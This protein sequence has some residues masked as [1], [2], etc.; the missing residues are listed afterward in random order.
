MS[1]Y[2]QALA[3]DLT[4]VF[5]C[6]GLLARF[7]NL[8]LSHPAVPYIVF[9]VHTVT[10]RL[11][12]LLNGAPTLYADTIY[13]FEP[14]LA[15]EIVRAALY[16]D[17][18]FLAVTT[19]WIV[20]KLPPGGVKPAQSSIMLEARLLR[21]VLF[22]SFCL[23][24]VGLRLVTKVPGIDYYDWDPASAWNS[25]SYILMLPSWFGLA[26]LGHIYF[27][28]FKKWTSLLLA[29]YLVLMAL[30]GGLRF[31]FIIGL[32][33]AVQI[34]V[35]H[36]H[37]RW[38]TRPMFVAL[39][40]SALLFFPM[41]DAGYL[42]LY[43]GT[44]EEVSDTVTDSVTEVAAGSAGDQM[45]LDEYASGLTL[46]DLQGK[47]YYGSIYLPLLTLPVPRYFWP[48]KP[49]LAGFVTD[50]SSR[51]RP[52]ATSGMIV[53][54]LGEAYAN[55]GLAG[56]LIVPPILALFLVIFYR[57][58]YLAPPGSVMRFS[59]IL[60]AVNLI[61]VFRDG[62]VSIV[63]FTFVNMMPLVVII[64]LHLGAAAVRKRRHL[65]LASFSQ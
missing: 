56:I 50:I 65:G 20:V 23:G 46:L 2:G 47:K 51:S 24:V 32:L 44:F 17:I 26:V 36:R 64:L 57:H 3:I 49:V 4:T 12:G 60:L 18:A 55:F 14:V 39:A 52:M 27:Y 61:Q 34:W 58:A 6:L 54:Y 41:K 31:R 11:A 8:Q 59:Y 1:D 53:T 38:P 43:G 35:E 7:G 62:L 13:G 40:A 22:F 42:I 48:D 28:G 45:F 33:L 5:L 16:A 10:T 63:V 29:F 25:S 30:Q 9:H 19:V 15:E 37:R 21:P